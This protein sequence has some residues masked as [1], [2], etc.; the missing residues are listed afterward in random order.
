M[1]RIAM[2]ESPFEFLDW[3]CHDLDIFLRWALNQRVSQTGSRIPYQKAYTGRFWDA[4]W[5]EERFK[6]VPKL[7]GTDPIPVTHHDTS[8]HETIPDYALQ[9]LDIQNEGYHSSGMNLVGSKDERGKD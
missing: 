1:E 3:A 9:T 2:D 4:D 8:V 6:N 7:Q 5:D